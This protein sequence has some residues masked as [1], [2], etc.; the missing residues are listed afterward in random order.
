MFRQFS[1]DMLWV[2]RA[3]RRVSQTQ[4][5]R[6]VKI[7]Q[8]KLSKIEAGIVQPTEDL[9]AAFGNELQ[10]KERF[11]LHSEL[12]RI[13]PVSFHRKRQ[14][15][16]AGDWEA[17]NARAEV[18]RVTLVEM[19]RA[20]ELSSKRAA[21]PQID[22]DQYDGRVDDIA[23]A[24]R[25]T[26]LLP[27]GPVDD[28]V[29]I[30]ED[31]GIVVIPFDFGTELIDAFCQH[32]TDGLPPLIFINSRMKEVD[33]IRFS[34]CHE[35]GHLVMH[36]MPNKIMEEQANQF[37]AAF[38]MPAQDIRHSLRQLSL[39]KLMALKLYWKVSMQ[40]LVRRARDLGEITE[41]A[42]KYYMVEMSKRGWRSKEPV[43]INKS[44]ENPVTIKQMFAAHLNDLKYSLED[45]CD[46]FG[47]YRDDVEE[48]YPQDRPRLRLAV[49]N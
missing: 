44:I 2:A 40:A 39:E 28:V 32:A 37:A 6:R 12:R 10:F 29:E 26:W 8:A 17:I 21:A 34:I 15:L 19:L 7:S 30:C 43:S 27:R 38:L 31:A 47:L 49:S 11:F 41:R 42:F 36:R 35:L 13:S 4:L 22:P 5:A 23:S 33:R 9:L 24:V 46:L 16:S 45:I 14:K 18:Y 3:L 1:S 25:Q 48:M 20:V